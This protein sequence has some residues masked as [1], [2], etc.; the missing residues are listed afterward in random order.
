MRA[1]FAFVVGVIVVAACG[2]KSASATAPLIV[3]SVS[4]AGTWA[5]CIV[6]PH[7][8]C[9]PVT[10]TL[11]DSSLTDSTAAVT[12][13]GNWGDNVV[14]KG[15]LLDARITLSATTV[16]VLQGWSF[17]GVVAGN[18][19]TGNLTM[20]GVDSTFTTTFTRSQ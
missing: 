2:K 13:T 20:P 15:N 3:D 16:A 18:T 14:I 19:L 12:G 9:S 6:E 5:G 8:T 11:S 7:V 4:V 17:V 1:V 10:M